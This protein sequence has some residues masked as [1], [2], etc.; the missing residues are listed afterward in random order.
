MTK[1]EVADEKEKALK[2]PE[3]RTLLSDKSKVDMFKTIAAGSSEQKETW[4]Q[5]QVGVR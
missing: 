1:K 5:N 4:R 2:R 3:G